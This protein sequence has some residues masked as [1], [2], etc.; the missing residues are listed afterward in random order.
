[1]LATYHIYLYLLCGISRKHST[2][3]DRLRLH[4]SLRVLEEKRAFLHHHP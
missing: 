3:R 2:T 4:T 1:M